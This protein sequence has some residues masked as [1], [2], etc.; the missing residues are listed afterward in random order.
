[1]CVVEL[2]R[3]DCDAICVETRIAKLALNVGEKYM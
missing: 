1:M 3:F 2:P